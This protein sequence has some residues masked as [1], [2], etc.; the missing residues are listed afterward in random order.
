MYVRTR[1]LYSITQSIYISFGLLKV[2]AGTYL[3]T[4][5]DKKATNAVD[6]IAKL[7]LF[8]SNTCIIVIRSCLSRPV[9]VSQI[10][11]YVLISVLVHADRSTKFSM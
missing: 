3:F 7:M 6:L 5:N 11:Y 9:R 1:V 4:V 8:K 2:H 10:G